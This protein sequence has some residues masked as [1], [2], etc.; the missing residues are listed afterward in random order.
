MGLFPVILCVSVVAVQCRVGR[1]GNATGNMFGHYRRDH[2]PLH[3]DV[4]GCGQVCVSESDC[5]ERDRFD[6]EVVG[7][8]YCGC[9]L[10]GKHG[11]ACCDG[12]EHGVAG[13][14]GVER[15]VDGVSHVVFVSVVE[16]YCSS[17]GCGCC[18][19]CGVY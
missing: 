10:A 2:E 17:D 7:V 6:V 4:V 12:D 15:D 11:C 14:V 1:C 19:A 8:N 18:E 9:W 13:V 3:V 16:V 5:D